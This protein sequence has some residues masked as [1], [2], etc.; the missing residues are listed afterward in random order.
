MPVSRWNHNLHK[1][2]ASGNDSDTLNAINPI[3]LFLYSEQKA[4]AL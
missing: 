2:H 4:S 3:I 1:I